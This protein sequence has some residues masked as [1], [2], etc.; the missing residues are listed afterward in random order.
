MNVTVSS[1][2][3]L[4]CAGRV[5]QLPGYT[6]YPRPVPSIAEYHEADSISLFD[7]CRATFHISSNIVLVNTL[8]SLEW[9]EVLLLMLPL[10]SLTT[11][12]PS[13]VTSSGVKRRRLNRGTDGKSCCAIAA[14]LL[15]TNKAGRIHTNEF[16]VCY[17]WG[18][19]P[20]EKGAHR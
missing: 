1:E 7:T 14:S 18:Q 19:G 16:F 15:C 2:G 13:L 17:R 9:L 12:W 11:V 3:L 4:L 10:L 5:H 6:A 8:P 20:S